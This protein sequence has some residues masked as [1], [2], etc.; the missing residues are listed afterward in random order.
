MAR[1]F[2]RY[3]KAGKF[4]DAEREARERHRGLWADENPVPP[5]EWRR[6]RRRA[7]QTPL[8]VGA[9]VPGSTHPIPRPLMRF[10]S[11]ATRLRFHSGMVPSGRRSPAHLAAVSVAASRAANDN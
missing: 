1:R 5:W 4:T 9:P 8:N 3:D 2:V 7:A 11:A 6:E 10:A